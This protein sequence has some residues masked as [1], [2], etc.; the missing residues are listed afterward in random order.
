LGDSHSQVPISA[1]SFSITDQHRRMLYSSKSTNLMLMMQ[2]Y[3]FYTLFVTWLLDLNGLFDVRPT[4]LRVVLFKQLKK[5][6]WKM[7]Y[8]KNLA[9]PMIFYTKL[10]R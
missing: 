10:E 9:I 5:H 3:A 7:K 6:L 2:P 1:L 8:Y 4:T